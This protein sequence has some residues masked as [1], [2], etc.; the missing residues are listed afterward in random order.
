[1]TDSLSPTDRSALMSRVRNKNT[2]PE[3]VV[4]KLAH[5]LGL[6]FRLHRKNLPGT[7]DLVFPR[8]RSAVFVHGCF[9]H[10]HPG[11]RR[12]IVP[13][14][15]ARKWV[16]KF[17]RNRSRDVEAECALKSMGWDVLVIW[18]C[19]TRSE[20]LL[21]KKLIDHFDLSYPIENRSRQS[22]VA[23]DKSNKGDAR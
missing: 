4:R 16:S 20:V 23:A 9:W 15:N 13:K 14:T 7:P 18:E 6:R 8:Y 2:A 12:A 3:V 22:H 1:M 19:E 21:T 10:Q 5:R 17:E 11:C